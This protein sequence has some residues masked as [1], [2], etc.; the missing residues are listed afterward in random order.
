MAL[1]LQCTITLLH[2]Y[3]GHIPGI[4]PDVH[5]NSKSQPTY[6]TAQNRPTTPG[7][8]LR[9]DRRRP[10]GPTDHSSSGR[11]CRPV[12]A[13]LRLPTRGPTKW[14]ISALALDFGFIA[15]DVLSSRAFG[16]RPEG[17]VPNS[18]PSEPR[19]DL[20]EGRGFDSL[21]A[22]GVPKRHPSGWA[23]RR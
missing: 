22:V 13:C 1:R 9:P 17:G 12:F 6:G 21:G 5:V 2:P 19:S 18:S 16:D 4:F 20:R 8:P 14:A 23:P 7:G 15:L 3:N 11:L 10:W